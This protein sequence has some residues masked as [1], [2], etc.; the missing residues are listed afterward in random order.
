[1]AEV[2]VHP[3][4]DHHHRGIDRRNELRQQLRGAVVRQL[5]H[6]RVE[7]RAGAEQ[8]PLGVLLDVAGQQHADAADLDHQHHG[9]LVRTETGDS[10]FMSGPSTV[11]V[12]CP[13][14]STVPTRVLLH[15]H[16]GP[17]GVVE[18]VTPGRRGLPAW[19]DLDRPDSA[20]RQHTVQPADVV[21]VQVGE[22][23][24]RHA[25]HAESI[26]TPG[27]HARLR[28]RIHHHRL[29]RHAGGDHETVALTDVAADQPPVGGWPTGSEGAHRHQHHRRAG[30]HRD[31]QQAGPAEPEQER[32]GHA[33]RGQQ[34]D[35][36][37][38]ST[39]RHHRG[40][41][42]GD[43]VRGRRRSTPRTARRPAHRAP[44][45]PA[46][47]RPARPRAHR[48]GAR[49][50]PPERPGC[51]PGSPTPQTVPLSA[52]I[53]GTVARW[54]TVG[55][56]SRA[57]H[58]IGTRR[59]C[60]AAVQR[61]A[62]TTI[63]AVA[64]TDSAKPGSTPAPGRPPA[65]PT[66]PRPAPAA[67]IGC[68]PTTARPSAI[69]PITTARSTDGSAPTTTTRTVS[70]TAPADRG[71]PRAGPAKRQ[72]QQADQDRDMRPRHG[73]QVGQAGDL[74]VLGQRRTR[75]RRSIAQHDAGQQTGRLA[76]GRCRHGDESLPELTGCAAA[77]RP[78]PRPPPVRTP[79]S[80]S[81]SAS[82]PRP[83]ARAA[84]EPI[85]R[86]PGGSPVNSSAG[87]KTIAA[88]A[89]L[90]TR[91]RDARTASVPGS[92]ARAPPPGPGPSA[93]GSPATVEFDG[94]AAVTSGEGEGGRVADRRQPQR[95]A[96]GR[97]H[98]AEQHDGGDPNGAGT[99]YRQPPRPRPAAAATATHQAPAQPSRMAAS[100]PTHHAIAATPRRRSSGTTG[101]SSTASGAA[102][103]SVIRHVTP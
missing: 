39:A 65:A 89:G 73:Q 86:A 69:A 93:T 45:P 74:R 63:A 35:A 97:S 25:A 80:P 88:G 47:D 21:G 98:R 7:P 48:P 17:G 99:P 90:E 85:T 5:Q 20:A 72:Q 84:H 26:E 92:S 40:R 94:P 9:Q 49:P 51:S 22:H 42:A 27:H 60:R 24:Q 67:P 68:G 75:S 14:T 53:S 71:D 38:A 8:R 23:Q 102:K 41:P 11:S 87:P 61:G 62:T 36:G 43:P 6:I 2:V 10:M 13:A 1:M 19:P 44:P 31:G 58:P 54:A 33:Q 79:R 16:T 56:T 103:R 32:R 28:P 83:R 101:S 78:A 64:A 95:A 59:F 52:A 50:V 15:R 66:P 77:T 100:V 29:S 70:S 3:D 76:A 82:G 96:G 57:A 37:A 30:R 18:H 4:A 46:A 12:N 91:C 34:H 81:P 55:T